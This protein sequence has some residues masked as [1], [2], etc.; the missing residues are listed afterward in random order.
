[1][2]RVGVLMS[3]AA[4]NT[5]YQSYLTAFIQGLR[6]LG[7]SEGQNIQI[8]VRW[9]PADAG[10]ARIYAAQLIGLMP[11]VILV[12]STINLTEVQQA[13]S[14]VPIVFLAVSDPVAQGFVTSMSHPG[15]NLTG[16]SRYEFS[17]GSKWLGLLKEVAPGLTR[18]AVMFNPDQS[19]QT[20]FFMQAI[21]AAAPSLDV[22]AIAVPVRATADIEAALADF[23]SSPNGGLILPTGGFTRIRFTMIAGLAARYRLPS[24]AANPNFAKA[25]GLMEY[26]TP[27]VL[28]QYREAASYVDR[29]L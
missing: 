1:M 26:N 27:D 14:T 13:T 2:R 7:W 17:I 8:E 6:Q 25:G 10:L 12:S 28:G 5:E 22:Q 11:D 18:A 21:E 23:A 20:K 24:I 4:T 9:N 29:I 19:P 15:G 16:F 3:N